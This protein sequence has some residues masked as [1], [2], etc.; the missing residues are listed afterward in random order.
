MRRGEFLERE[1]M[2]IFFFKFAI[3]SQKP[4]FP[5]VILFYKEYIFFKYFIGNKIE[6]RNNLF[7][8]IGIM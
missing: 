5:M 2:I 8:F 4:Y 3:S 1:R 6:R 7:L